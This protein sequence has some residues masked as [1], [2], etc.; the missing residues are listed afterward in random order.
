MR[1]SLMKRNLLICAVAFLCT[2]T[3]AWAQTGTTSLRGVI[4]D[5]SGATVAGAK[6]VLSNAQ[7]GL[8]RETSTNPAGE[9]EFLALPPGVYSLTAEKDGFRMAELNGLQLL[10]NTPA[11]SNL[12]LEIGTTTQS[13]EVTAAA[14]TL[15]TTDA[16]L[17]NTF[18]EDRVKQLPMEARNVAELLSLQAGVAYLGNRETISEQDSDT[19]N[20]AVNGARSDQSNITLDGVDVN[21][22][23]KGYA[24]DSVLPIT[25]DSVQ[26][27]RVTTSNYNADEGRSS[28]AQ[29]ALVTKSGTNSLH[30]AIYEYNRNTLASAND[31]LVKLAELQ[32]GQPNQ[33]LELIRNNFGGALGGPIKKDRLFFFINYEGE[34]QAD[35]QS[36]VR[37]VPSVALRDGVITYQCDDPTACPGGTVQGL[38]GS[39][40]IAPGNF[41]LNPAQIKAMDPVGVG[42]ST[43]VM[44]PYFNSFP[45][46]NDNTVGDGVNFQGYRFKGSNLV[47]DNWYIARADYKITSNGNQTLFWRGALRNDSNVGVPYLPGDL[48]EQTLVDY[49]KG[50]SVGY[51]AVLRANLVNNFRWGYTRQSF[52][53][54][55][56]QTQPFVEFR[57]LND[58]TGTG[59][60][61]NAAFEY[62]P[63]LTYQVPVNNFVDDISWIKGRHTLSFGGNIS[64]LRNPQSTNVNSYNLAVTN[65]SWFI[66][67]GLGDQ[68]V[69]GFFDPNCSQTAVPVTGACFDGS[70][71]SAT[72]PHYPLIASSFLTNYDYPMIAL[73]GMVN[74]VT[75]NYNFNKNG[76]ALPEGQTVSRRFADDGYEMYAQDSW[77]IKPNLTVTY[78]LRYSLFSPP[79]ETNG[80][81]VTPNL[82]LSNWFQERAQNMEQGIGSNAAPPISFNLGG[83][84]NGRPGF[85]NW[86]TK[87]FAPR[88]AVAYSPSATDGFW[89]ALFGGPGK[90]TI[91][92]GA[93]IVYDRVGPALLAT[94]DQSGSFGLSTALSNSAGTVSPTTAPRITG[95]N[96]IP[97]QGTDGTV[98]LAP[99]P[100]STFP[101][102]FPSSGTGSFAVYWGMDQNLKT[103][104]SYTLDLSVGR[105]LGHGFTL[106]VAYVGRLSHRLLA[107]EDLATPEDIVDPKTKVDY[108]TAVTALAKL[109]RQ[110]I[111]ATSITPQMVGSTAQYWTDIIQPLQKGG[112]YL[113]PAGCGGSTTSALQAAYELFSCFSGNE[114]S[115]IQTLDQGGLTDANL[116]GVSYYGPGGPYAFLDPQFAAL[117]A[118][119][120]IGTASY[121][122]LQVNLRRHISHSLQFDFNYTYSRS[123]D[124]SSDANRIAAE[125]GLGSQVINAWDPNALKGVSDFDTPH[126]FN[127][128]WVWEMPF[129]KGRSIAGDSHGPLEALIGGWQLTG[130]ARWTSGF[131]VGVT[132]GSQWPTN[133]QLSGF[134]TQIAPVTAGGA[135]KNPDG[136]VNIFG[137][138]AAAAAALGSYQADFPGQVGARNTLR[139][140]GFAGLDLGLGKRWKMP[141]KESH[142]LQFRWEVFNALNLTRFDVS[143]LNLSI[144]NASTF[145]D[146]SGLLTNPRTMQ[147]ALRYEF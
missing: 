84:A 126:Q 8:R 59:V 121:N 48:P 57:G 70:S 140:D 123:I 98:L 35:Q 144:T 87:D 54:I 19:R 119:R 58:G 67:S 111:P 32:S 39:H 122:A 15:N 42:V 114:T 14:V 79:W 127:A 115:A 74:S 50:F 106:E 22:D 69:P 46:P 11:T 7:Q 120:S 94:F 4:T 64:I 82:N 29:V 128:N 25:A 135:V 71:P 24:F 145:G 83:P 93:G 13:V 1:W 49:S 60:P 143:T 92:M 141:W 56:N 109:Y 80:L 40:T 17:G 75:A 81:Q 5:K 9:Y 52:G 118:W 23:T 97:T 66:P 44:I 131:P 136:S 112:A 91:R 21:S 134:A 125:G 47:T 61:D 132:N 68:G 137:N 76:T 26:E 10:V 133:W 117:Y 99:A 78:G 142:S 18:D 85:Y 20:G 36:T 30:G 107:Q 96:S 89:K 72:E 102:T 37:V 130:L 104:Y 51:T 3:C 34:R 129:G 45:L 65:A 100:V 124:I 55:G 43:S 16:S 41:A 53:E 28:G 73:V 95:L 62:Q 108:F 146:Y 38:T 101:Q 86:D 12:T 90:S 27:F 63:T 88:L 31:Y 113:P 138:A 139:G 110:G 105:D 77:K 116:P 6:V 103:P 2:V 147:F 33:A